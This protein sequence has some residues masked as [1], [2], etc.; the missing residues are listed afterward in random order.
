MGWGRKRAPSPNAAM[1][2]SGKGGVGKWVKKMM[3]FDKRD[4]IGSKLSTLADRSP[5]RGTLAG[6][7]EW[8]LTCLNDKKGWHTC[9]ESL[10]SPT[11]NVAKAVAINAQINA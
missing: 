7:N 1:L 5:W 3:G 9:A 4:T 2:T 6:R 11:D 8:K 10:M